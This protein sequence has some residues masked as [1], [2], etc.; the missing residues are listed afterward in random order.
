MHFQKDVK[1]IVLK[2]SPKQLKHQNLEASIVSL[3]FFVRLHFFLSSYKGCDHRVKRTASPLHLNFQI[4]T[5]LPTK[6]AQLY[7]NFATIFK[8]TSVV[9][10]F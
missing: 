2:F 6:Y 5:Y 8:I 9:F 4:P 7:L 3:I 1:K 10:H